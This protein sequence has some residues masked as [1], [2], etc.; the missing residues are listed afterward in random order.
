[1]PQDPVSGPARAGSSQCDSEVGVH[2]SSIS[3]KVSQITHFNLGTVHAF[4][5][6][7][8]AAAPRGGSVRRQHI[9]Y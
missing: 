7:I 9:R 5:D 2:K 3:R 6:L 1:M 4:E 8:V